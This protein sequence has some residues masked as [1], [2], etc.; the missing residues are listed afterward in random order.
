MAA[1]RGGGETTPVTA[2]NQR[3]SAAV[4]GTVRFLV[5]FAAAIAAVV[6]FA[7]ASQARQ[8]EAIRRN[9][10]AIAV[11]HARL[12]FICE[13]LTEIRSLLAEGEVADVRLSADGTESWTG[14]ATQ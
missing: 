5:S 12:E 13:K 11:I 4:E 7:W 1:G 9:E 3:Y 14:D 6:A 8:D 2:P 10:T